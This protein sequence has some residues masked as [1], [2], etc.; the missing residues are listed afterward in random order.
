MVQ[1]PLQGQNQ[2]GQGGKITNKEAIKTFNRD[3]NR[4]NKVEKNNQGRA[5]RNR[6]HSPNYKGGHKGRETRNACRTF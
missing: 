2:Q 5:N 4:P 1:A 6:P 3:K